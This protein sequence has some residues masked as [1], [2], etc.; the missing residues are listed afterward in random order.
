MKN[1]TIQLAL[2]LGLLHVG[3]AQE[4]LND[5]EQKKLLKQA[6]DYFQ[7][8]EYTEAFKIY[9]VLHAQDTNNANYN[10]ELGM[11]I[12]EGSFNKVAA[13]KYLEKAERDGK[14]S[15][16][17]ELFYY[18]G[19]VYHLEHNFLFATA[20]YSTYMAE[21]LPKGKVGKEREAE[22]QAYIQQCEEGK[23]LMEKERDVLESMDKQT[24]NIRKYYLDEN[25]YVKIENLGDEVNSAFSEYGPIIMDN[26]QTMLF[27][28][29]RQGST[30]GGVYTDGQYY[31]DIYVSKHKH[32]LFTDIQNINNMD[33]FDGVLLNTNKHNATVSISDDEKDLYVYVDN[34]IDHINYDG[35]K[36][37]HPTKFSETFNRAG[38][39]VTSA[40]I[41]PDGSKMYLSATRFDCIGGRDL[42]ISENLGDDKWG[43]L[44]NLG[45]VLN[46]S[47]DEDS[48]FLLNDTTLYF[49]SKGHSSIGG[50]DV[51]VTY[52]RN[53]KWSVPE[54]LKIPV[55]SPYDE[56]N[57]MYGHDGAHAYIASNR[58][59]GFGEFDI[60]KITEGTEKEIDEDMIK[61][62]GKIVPSLLIVD[63]IQLLENGDL[64]TNFRKR[65]DDEISMLRAND[66]VKAQ[67]VGTVVDGEPKDLARRRAL[68]AYNY[69]VDAGIDADR[70]EVLYAGMN[71]K[72]SEMEEKHKKRNVTPGVDAPFEAKYEQ[73]IYFG[74]NSSLVTEYSRGKLTSLF[75]YL[76][77]KPNAKVYLSGHA[78]HV[79]HEQYNLELSKKRVLSVE[80]YMRSQN[81]NQETRLE[82]F[83]ESAPRYEED[84][85][86][87]DP[88]K[89]IY[90]RRVKIVVF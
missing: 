3:V 89:Q 76:K 69:M 79:G 42:Y 20:S 38:S 80:S 41:S 67:I 2:I 57:Y 87:T 9:N 43:E 75:E 35:E 33:M 46:T 32:G 65:L 51:F 31:E 23:D 24:A 19:R 5:I 16:M 68:K 40:T 66:N 45:D 64:D 1:I 34:H 83:G 60:Y 14:R 74:F 28:S 56:I 47:Q 58:Q 39:Q 73:T 21:S 36:W 62:I 71:D 55:N 44:K 82:Y 22:V 59:G 15:E 13:K 72:D 48:P 86:Q 54:N 26:G 70:L 52:L 61:G 7:M 85:V 11:C 53:G 30:G 10:Y 29:R 25:R 12:Y 17:P 18:M 63:D 90:N 27:T 50:Y 77:D 6:R 37:V 4:R 81:A 88:T 78:D 84:V 8:E 49:S